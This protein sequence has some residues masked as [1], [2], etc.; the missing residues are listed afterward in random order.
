MNRVI[1]RGWGD[2]FCLLEGGCS[3]FPINKRK[4]KEWIH[5]MIMG[6]WWGAGG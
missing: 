1:H 5:Y 3:N 6:S 2:N 4:T